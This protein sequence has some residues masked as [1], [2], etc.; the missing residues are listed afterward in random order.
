MSNADDDSVMAEF[1]DESKLDVSG[2]TSFVGYG[3]SRPTHGDGNDTES[4]VG[5][6][7]VSGYGPELSR[8]TQRW[9]ARVVNQL[10]R[11]FYKSPFALPNAVAGLADIRTLC[12]ESAFE[13]IEEFSREVKDVLQRWA[14]GAQSVD[15]DQKVRQQVMTDARRAVDVFDQLMNEDPSKLPREPVGSARSARDSMEPRYSEPPETKAPQNNGKRKVRTR[16]AAKSRHRHHTHH[17]R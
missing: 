2:Q 17:E 11:A 1:I 15:A 6:A 14:S 9:M 10:A 12:E 5:G 7:S 13:S 16:P 4:N 3:T 8:A